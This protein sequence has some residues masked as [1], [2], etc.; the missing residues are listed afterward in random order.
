MKI[1][2]TLP[3]W[4][5][6]RDIVVLAGIELAAY[7]LATQNNFNI[8]QVRCNFCGECCKG[9]KPNSLPFINWEGTCIHLIADGEKQICGLG[10][11][12]SYACCSCDPI[13][14]RE[15]NTQCCITYVKV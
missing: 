4:C 8:K 3:D 1:E 13:K 11:Y 5:D 9:H 14:G 2:I 7:K 6:E 15:K 10:E 12:R